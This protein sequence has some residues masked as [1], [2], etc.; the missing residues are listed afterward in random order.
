MNGVLL[1]TG[2]CGTL[3]GEVVRRA[4]IRGW[5]V[6]ATWWE[7]PPVVE[8]EWV[9]CDVRDRGAVAE[10]MRGVDAVLHTAY[11]SGK[12]EWETKRMARASWN[13]GVSAFTGSGGSRVTPAPPYGGCQKASRWRRRNKDGLVRTEGKTHQAVVGTSH[14]GWRQCEAV[15]CAGPAVRRGAPG[16]RPV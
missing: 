9:R 3:G 2:G 7:R 12:G 16:L 14:S 5:R 10:A 6:R 1:V 8:G 15:L 13:L 4:P 11:R